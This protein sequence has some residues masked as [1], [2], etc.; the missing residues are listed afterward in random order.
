MLSYSFIY[1]LLPEAND[2][3]HQLLVYGRLAV[4]G[5]FTMFVGFTFTAPVRVEGVY[6]SV[7]VPCVVL[8]CYRIVTDGL[9]VRVDGNKPFICFSV[10]V[11]CEVNILAFYLIYAVCL[12]LN[13]LP[14]FTGKH[15]VAEH[16]LAIL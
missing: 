12:T 16:S 1:L 7:A 11:L 8:E 2:A 10:V 3:F 13:T 15:I 6:V 5:H 14:A 4:V 9:P